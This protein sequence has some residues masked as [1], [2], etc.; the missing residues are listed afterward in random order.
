MRIPIMAGNWKMYKTATEAID[1]VTRLHKEL[2]DR[3][4]TEV[5]VAPSFVA[6]A[7]VAER[8]CRWYEMRGAAM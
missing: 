3:G 6:L 7:P 5:V 1:F 8:Q 4:E 2:G